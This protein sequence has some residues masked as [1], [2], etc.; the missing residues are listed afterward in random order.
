MAKGGGGNGRNQFGGG[1]VL[2]VSVM[3]KDA[4][5]DGW[6][7][8]GVGAQHG[9]VVIRFHKQAAHSLQFRDDPLRDMTK[10]RRNCKRRFAM[11][12]DETHGIGGIMWHGKRRDHEIAELKGAIC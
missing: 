5:F 3:R 2:E 1:L 12:D 11:G 10:I 4:G 7:A 9:Q 8:F 6:R